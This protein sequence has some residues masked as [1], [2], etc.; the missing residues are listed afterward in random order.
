MPWQARHQLRDDQAH[1]APDLCLSILGRA[2][3]PVGITQS[4]YMQIKRVYSS[5]S[6]SKY[7]YGGKYADGIYR[8]S[9][10]LVLYINA[11]R[12]EAWVCC[13]AN[14]VLAVRCGCKAI[15]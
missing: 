8:R 14:N 2:L 13:H 5:H 10:E 4:R 11:C 12:S 9:G 15:V 7:A 3:S 1:R 6:S